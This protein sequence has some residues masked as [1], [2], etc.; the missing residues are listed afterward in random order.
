MMIPFCL[1]VVHICNIH[2]LSV[3]VMFAGDTPRV[4]VSSRPY[5]VKS[6]FPSAVHFGTPVGGVVDHG[7]PELGGVAPGTPQF[8]SY[9]SLFPSVIN[10]IA[11]FIYGVL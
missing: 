2:V 1:M 8:Q 3:V 4:L 5:A 7:Q 9:H 10:T 11:F 6:A